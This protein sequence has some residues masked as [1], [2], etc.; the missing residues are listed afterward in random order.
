VNL[1]GISIFV[2]LVALG[3]GTLPYGL[4]IWAF[5]AW[6]IYTSIGR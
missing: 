2:G 6:V 3:L 4:A 1:G 5:L